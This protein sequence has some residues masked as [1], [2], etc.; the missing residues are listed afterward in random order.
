MA[1]PTNS[2]KQRRLVSPDQMLRV[3]GKSEFFEV[4]IDCLSIDKIMVRFI[5]YDKAAPTGQRQQATVPIYLDVLD[6][7][8]IAGDILSGRM[9][10]LG[11]KSRQAA[12]ESGSK[13][14]REVLSRMGGTSASRSNRSDGKPEYRGFKITPGSMQPWIFSAETGPGKQSE[15]GLISPDYKAPETIVRV[16]MTDDTLKKVAYAF[17]LAG[18]VWAMARFQPTVTDWMNKRSEETRQAMRERSGSKQDPDPGEYDDGK[19]AVE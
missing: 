3:D 5:K 9:S 2:G 15:Q 19:G 11:E 1:A 10:K 16:P 7:M 17:Q 6:A 13:Y 12:K 14:P 8:V 18:Q 4:M